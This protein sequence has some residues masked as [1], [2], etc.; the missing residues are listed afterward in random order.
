MALVLFRRTR[1]LGGIG[2]A[3]TAVASAGLTLLFAKAYAEAQQCGTRP[4]DLFPP[5]QRAHA[6]LANGSVALS[7]VFMGLG[8]I[9]LALRFSGGRPDAPA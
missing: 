2:G 7:G 1:S 9:I 6:A 5:D 4:D 3:A 8:A